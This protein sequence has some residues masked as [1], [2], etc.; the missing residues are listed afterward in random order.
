LRRAAVYKE[1]DAV[2][3]AAVIRRK[4]HDGFGNFFGV[5]VRPKGVTEAAC[6]N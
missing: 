5:P 4:E 2:D 1:F 3:E 6:P